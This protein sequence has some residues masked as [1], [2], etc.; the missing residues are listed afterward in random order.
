MPEITREQLRTFHLA[1]RELD[2]YRPESLRPSILDG[3][4]LPALESAYPVF[5]AP[6]KAPR[7]LAGAPEKAAAINE[8]IGDRAMVSAA[9]IR[10]AA[11]LPQNGWFISFR[12]E[13]LPLLYGAVLSAGRKSARARFL[14][15]LKQ[16]I[17]SLSNLLAID[18]AHRAGPPASGEISAAL[19]SESR[20]FFRPEVLEQALQG[21]PAPAH[22]MDAERRARCEATLAVLEQALADFQQA[23]VFRLFHSAA[24]PARIEQFGGQSHPCADPCD[25]ALEFC[26]RKLRLFAEVLRALR[27]AQLEASAAFDPAIHAAPI[28]RL[29][30]QTADPEDLAALPGVVVLEQADRLAKMSLTSFARLLRSGR[31]V[32]ILI[33][34]PGLHVENPGG[35]APD[36][37]HL[38]MTHR[39]AFV[40][41]SSM[42]HL[43]HL[44]DGFE[45]MARSLRPSVAVVAVPEDVAA[46][47]DRWLAAALC[48]LSRAFPLFR[49]DPEAGA[50]W[51]ER[52]QMAD[53]GAAFA[54][55]NAAHAMAVSEQF[56]AHFRVIPSRAWDG[57]QMELQEYLARYQ[58]APPLAIPYLLVANGGSEPQR[59]ILTRELAALCRDR[60]QAWELFSELAGARKQETDPATLDQARR[61]GVKDAIERTL[62]LL[63]NP[64]AL[65]HRG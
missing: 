26:D 6:G 55:L 62:A 49:Y 35:T 43:D 54:V 45:K 51:S 33:P 7:S 57:E 13:A 53:P 14:E 29:D 56:Q 25:T 11:E 60:A 31:P 8:E 59:A 20:Q 50:R 32:Q 15:R 18:D 21:T 5:V 23:P 46:P 41:Q 52:F 9:E 30:W 12:A 4:P 22:R 61:E 1:G 44:L 24:A 40:L 28:A 38:S 27:T 10:S 2:E 63:A 48:I 34:S 64:G 37:G 16:A 17:A 3:L 39:E 19:G 42:A 65:A 47:P 58:S 36:F